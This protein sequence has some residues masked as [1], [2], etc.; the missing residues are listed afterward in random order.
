MPDNNLTRAEARQRAQLLSDVSYVV[1]LD[2]TGG[3]ETFGFETTI[4]FRCRRPGESTFLDL[5][6][7]AVTVIELN[8]ETVP[9]DRFNGQRV[10]LEGLAA[11]NVVRVVGEGEYSHTGVGLHRFVDPVDE[12]VYLHTQMEPFDAHRVYPCFDQPDLKAPFTLNV[13]LPEGWTAISNE[14]AIDGDTGEGNGPVRF[15]T[16]VPLSTYVTALVAGPFHRVTSRHGDVDLGLFCRQ[17]LAEFL[18]D[19]ELFEL[20]GQGLDYFTALFDQ[21]YPYT[22]YDQLFV[23]EFNAGAMENAGCVT[24]SEGYVFRSKVTDTARMGR[25]GTLLHE[26]AHMW[27]G[28]LVTMRWWDDLWLNE[29]FATYMATQASASATRF[30]PTSWVRFTQ[31]IKTF[32][33]AQDQ[34]PSTHPISADIVDTDAVRVHFDGITYM[35]GASVLRQ[36]IAWVGDE[37]FTSGI[38]SY[39]KRHGGGN[40]ELTDFLAALEEGS[41]RQLAAWSKEWLETAGVNTMRV[42]L[43]VDDATDT[44]TG[45]TLL[46]EAPADHPT[47]RSHRLAV[48]LYRHEGGRLT[49][50][51]RVELDAI[52]ARTDVTDLV[53]ESVPDLLLINDDDL[54]YTKV[55][56]DARSVATLVDHLSDLDDPLARALCWNALWDMVRDAELAARRFVEIVAAHAPLETEL[57]TMQQLLGQAQSAISQ[58]S[59]PAHRAALHRRLGEVARRF[60]ALAEPGSD[61]QLT[62][63]HLMV[64]TADTADELAQLRRLLDGDETIE[65]L[66]IDTDFRW[67]LV[68]QLARKGAGDAAL[69][70]AEAER[71]PT[72]IGKRRRLGAL[73]ARPDAESKAAA[74][75]QLLD[76]RDLPL[77]SMGAIAGGFKDFD[78]EEWLAPYTSRYPE[79][80]GAIWDERSDEEAGL[81]TGALFPNWSKDERTLA[82]ADAALAIESIPPHGKRTIGEIK[83]TVERAMRAQACDRAE[84]GNE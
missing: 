47:L 38:R 30:G 13:L 77:Q 80:L 43:A 63:A 72:D 40:A 17:S 74:W 39:F 10:E 45:V 62:F 27:F 56:L 36:L 3:P 9:T 53:G 57:A 22:K 35:K 32:A 21:P 83:D 23:P 24:F 69:I 82:A 11:D 42:E 73:A 76:D 66:A 79:V 64:A 58:Y 20:T 68:G 65:G 48:G 2:L 46:Q 50:T 6:A 55:R 41:G 81:L 49:R 54:A 25:A 44:Y 60:L 67:S 71:D 29:S 34:L 75:K 15:K 19:V 5:T 59:D 52:G 61:R 8:G 28:D 26:M 12:Q 16:T 78:Q 7:P 14:P 84:G 31:G 51:R 70:D 33:Y 4:G 37:G 18:D 1:D